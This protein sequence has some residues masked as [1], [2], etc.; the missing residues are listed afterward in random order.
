ML[1]AIIVTLCIQLLC[2]TVKH[3]W[4]KRKLQFLQEQSRL[5]QKDSKEKDFKECSIWF[6]D[7]WENCK[8]LENKT[9]CL[10]VCIY[11]YIYTLT[12]TYIYMSSPLIYFTGVVSFL[13]HIEET[14][15]QTL[16]T[17]INLGHT[18]ESPGKFKNIWAQTQRFW[19]FYIECKVGIRY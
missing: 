9:R 18:L 14:K 4:Q 1:I 13:L 2:K 10:C 11:T 5:L 15:T 8:R 16:K 12:H 17:I 3:K 7:M 6:R 19:L